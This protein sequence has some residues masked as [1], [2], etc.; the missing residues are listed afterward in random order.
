MGTHSRCGFRFVVLGHRFQFHRTDGVD[1]GLYRVFSFFSFLL[2]HSTFYVLF[3]GC[4]RVCVCVSFCFSFHLSVG[5]TGDRPHSS[6]SSNRLLPGFFFFTGFSVSS[7]QQVIGPVRADSHTHKPTHT[8]TRTH[9][10]THA[11]THLVFYL[12]ASTLA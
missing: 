6:P 12:V 8:H 1:C 10:Y 5:A 7:A 9:T 2:F 3:I 11:R 4:V